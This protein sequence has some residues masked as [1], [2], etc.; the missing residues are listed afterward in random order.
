MS[1]E[2][3][4]RA[5][6]ALL[7]NV[8]VWLTLAGVLVLLARSQQSEVGS[9][10]LVAVAGALLSGAGAWA[11]RQPGAPPWGLAVAAAAAQLPG[12]VTTPAGLVALY[13]L[14]RPDHLKAVFPHR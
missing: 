6:L 9:E 13:W 8:P 5:A 14:F 3:A 12:C 2:P 7:V 11:A 1:P 4:H 10:P